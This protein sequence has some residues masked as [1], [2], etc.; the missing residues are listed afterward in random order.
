VIVTRDELRHFEAALA[1]SF[2]KRAPMHL[3]LGERDR[4]AEQRALA[5]RFV[6]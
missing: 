1:Q 4:D 3:G 6:G 2:E 5:V